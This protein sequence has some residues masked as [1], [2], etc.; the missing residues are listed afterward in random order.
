[1]PWPA[2]P[3]LV[4]MLA[5]ALAPATLASAGDGQPTLAR[6]SAQPPAVV[7]RWLTDHTSIAPSTVVS[8]GDEYIVAVLS[9]RV[10]DPA[11]P[12]VMRVEIRAEM[13]DPDAESANL[14][15]SLS[16]SLDINCDDLTSHFV[17]VRA[18]AG[19]NLSG[20]VQVTQPAE[21]WVAD[22]RGSYFE[23]IDAAV[24]TS[25][26]PRPLIAARA[27]AA[28]A[29]PPPERALSA[30]L[31]QGEPPDSPR[32]AKRAEARP[33]ATHPAPEYAGSAAQ[34]AAAT[35]EAKAEAAL[36]ALRSAH[37][38]LMS[39]LATRIERTDRGGVAYFR[40]LVSGF[41]SPA[42]A[43]AFCHRIAAAGG[44]FIVR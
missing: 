5:A 42:T 15:R 38:T 19:I 8:V 11:K 23:D 16:A 43:A 34:I 29:E 7:A 30:P 22:P 36:A 33:P 17:E 6:P 9:S 13:T 24:C 37:P 3:T 18:F 2:R 1:M 28:T 12:R 14:V 32:S 25:A 20:A 21:G 4:A 44:A 31:R 10:Q 35:S 41:K 26:A 27:A 40:A 39:G